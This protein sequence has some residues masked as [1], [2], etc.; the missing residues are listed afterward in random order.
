MLALATTVFVLLPS[1][2]PP[3]IQP[4][5]LLAPVARSKQRLIC[6]DVV[7]G[8]DDMRKCKDAKFGGI[9]QSKGKMI[10]QEKQRAV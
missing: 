5:V 2:L 8:E 10:Q 3:D 6:D 9:R 7:K 1:F 4:C